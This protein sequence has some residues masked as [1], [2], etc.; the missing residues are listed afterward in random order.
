MPVQFSLPHPFRGI[1]RWVGASYPSHSPRISCFDIDTSIEIW[2]V[3]PGSLWR[4]D[5][6]STALFFHMLEVIVT[7]SFL[8]L[9]LH[10]L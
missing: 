5:K 9:F 8:V 1:C 6:T 2:V 3:V 10:V 7:V 4:L